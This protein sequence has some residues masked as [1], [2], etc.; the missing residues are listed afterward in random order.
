M[1]SLRQT[2]REATKRKVAVG[3]F[4]IADLAGLKAI[5]GSAK[6]LGVPV[7]IGT[8]EGEAGF[9]GRKE[10]A[11]YIRALR[12][13][14]RMP[15]YL[16]SDH[17]HSFEE[18]KK[19]VAAGYDAILFDGGH[20]P[21]EENIKQTKKVVSYVKAKNKN[22]IVEGELGNIGSGSMIRKEIPKDAAIQLKDLTTPEDAVRFMKATGVD[23]L[24]PAVGNLH[25]ML[26]NAPNPALNIGRIRAIKDAIRMPM[27][28]HGGSGVADRDFVAAIEA[29]ITI[30][31]ISTELRVA[32][33]KGMDEAFR[34]DPDEI[35]PYKLFPQAIAGVREVATRRLQLF[36]KL[37]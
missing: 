19:A 17:T 6:D 29:G 4:N 15:I 24:A 12:E 8:S 13:E 26:A 25:G 3:H 37:L 23:M 20:L 31:H 16:N 30:V 2:L 21:I 27:V 9:L 22:I 28:L 14:L 34:A 11:A 35:A 1:K 5:V 32:W 18:I 36:N 10:I 33:R 7:I